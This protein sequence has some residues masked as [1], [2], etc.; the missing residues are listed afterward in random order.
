MFHRLLICTS[1]HDGLQRLV[2]FVPEIAASGVHQIVFLHVMPIEDRGIPKPDE[3][4]IQ[5]VRSQLTHTSTELPAGVEVKVEVQYGRTADR[6]L[7]TAQDYQSDLIILGTESRSL[8]TEKL[9]GST[10]T[11]LCQA[12]KTPV[13]ILRP[14]LISTYTVAELSLR[15][16]HLFRYL[17]VPY[18]GSHASESLIAYIHQA[19]TA[20]SLG[21]LQECFLLWVLEESARLDKLLHESRLQE[22]ETKLAAAKSR[23]EQVNLQVT[24][25]VIVGEPVPETLRIALEYDITA[26]A[27]ASDSL[28]RLGELSKPSFAG[29][30]LRRSWHPVVFFPSP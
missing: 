30:M 25:Q 19:G 20:Q 1:L 17:L 7:A 22:A 18:N 16:R 10:A 13:M 9:F 3:A 11:A 2:N 23:L 15:C 6:I 4:K 29:E 27:L 21:S 5:Q 12:R 8:L 28:G 14:Q 24:T 26:I